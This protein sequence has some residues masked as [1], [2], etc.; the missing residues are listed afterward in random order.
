DPLLRDEAHCLA[1][2][3]ACPRQADRTAKRLITGV[4]SHWDNLDPDWNPGGL[5]RPVRVVETG[6]VR[7]ARLRCLCVESTEGRRRLPLDVRVAAA[8]AEDGEPTPRA[9]R[10]VSRVTGP[11][12]RVLAE[13]TRDVTLAGGD[14][15]LSWTVDVD[16]PPRWWPRRLGDQPRC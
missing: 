1:I 13:G 2:E 15:M 3:V 8:G 9:A 11:D 4:F 16:Q 14:N 10:L 7:L 6:P 5:W 12:G